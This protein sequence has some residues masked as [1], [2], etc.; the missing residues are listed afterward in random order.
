MN[1]RT[2]VR[3]PSG[4]SIFSLSHGRDNL[5]IPCSLTSFFFLFLRI[6]LQHLGSRQSLPTSQDFNFRFISCRKN[7]SRLL[8]S[9]G[10]INLIPV[11]KLQGGYQLKQFIKAGVPLPF[12]SR[13]LHVH[14]II[15]RCLLSWLGN[16]WK[17]ISLALI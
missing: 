3:F 9:K 15:Y 12:P 14:L 5:K 10:L 2:W 16:A 11:I 7:G 6:F 8:C 1:G 17:D 4:T 13:K